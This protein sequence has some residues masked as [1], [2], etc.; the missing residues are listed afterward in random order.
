MGDNR[1]GTVFSLGIFI[2]LLFVYGPL[3]Q[4]LAGL[5]IGLEAIRLAIWGVAAVALTWAAWRLASHVVWRKAML[6]GV[7]AMM[8]VPILEV[9]RHLLLAED[10]NPR[11]ASRPAAGAIELRDPR[12]VY[13][14]V[15]DAYSRADVL[16]RSFGYD[17]S[18]FLEA[19]EKRGFS[20]GHESAA[21]IRG[22]F[23]ASIA[24][25]NG[26]RDT[27]TATFTPSRAAAS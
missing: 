20:I 3:S 22:R 23:A 26:S 18:A 27:A 12:N 7:L 2:V 8:I 10:G 25:S 4:G 16:R 24:R 13:W 17:N 14:L 1:I 11:P 5:G 6:F 9:G 19:L 15:T 21:S